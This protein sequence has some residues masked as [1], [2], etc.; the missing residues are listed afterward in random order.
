MEQEA[1]KKRVSEGEL[2]GDLGPP[3][4][5]RS[6][7]EEEEDDDYGPSLA[8]PVGQ[9]TESRSSDGKKGEWARVRLEAEVGEVSAVDAMLRSSDRDDWMTMLPSERKSSSQLDF[10]K[11]QQSVTAFS[12]RGVQ[13]RGDTSS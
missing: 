1:S 3:D 12:K 7:L 2:E 4:A 11:M 13:R 5:K 8:A 6:K 9:E 10:T